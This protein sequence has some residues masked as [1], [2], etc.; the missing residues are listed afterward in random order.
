MNDYQRNCDCSC[1]RCTRGRMTWGAVLLTLGGLFLLNEFTHI[2][3]HATWPVLLIV[4]GVVM[5]WRHAGSIEGH[6]PRDP[7]GTPQAPSPP[8]PPPN[9]GSSQ[10]PHV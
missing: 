3:F 10:V 8:Q 9:P 1:E 7:A 4:I 5:V 6:V 2:R